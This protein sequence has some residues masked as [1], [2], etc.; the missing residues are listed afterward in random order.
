VW[1][2]SALTMQ[3]A[4]LSEVGRRENNEDAA[5]AS[6]RLVAVAD[7]VG[8]ATAG[9]LASSLAIQKLIG[10]DSRRLVQPL[11][12]EFLD[13]VVDANAVIA[14]A[15]SY[16]PRYAGMGTTLTAVALSNEG[17]YLVANVGDSRS[18]LLRD[19]RLRRLTRDDSL[20]QELI[21]R[22]ALS[23]SEARQ[24]PQRSVVLEALD[25]VER[26]L[27]ALRTV[28]AQA[29]DRLLLCSDGVTDYLV[30]AEVAE[31]LRINDAAVAVR[32]LVDSALDHGSR[33]NITAVIADV[34]NGRDPGDGWLDSLPGPSQPR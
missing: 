21:D 15:T 9:E 3:T 11:Q 13:A 14:F 25:G 22:G 6:P 27:P 19:K 26:P 18:Y 30:D 1:A 28:R 29:G 7:G 33:D 16:D 34:V 23:E 12:R 32:R 4:V 20:V 5:F 17:A 2:V 8:G 31:L 10:L 24:H